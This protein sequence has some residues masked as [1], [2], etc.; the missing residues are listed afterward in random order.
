[1]KQQKHLSFKNKKSKIA[2]ENPDSYTRPRVCLLFL[3]Y[4]KLK[5]NL[6]IMKKMSQR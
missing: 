2:I 6:M 5:E 1:M 3:L 4:V